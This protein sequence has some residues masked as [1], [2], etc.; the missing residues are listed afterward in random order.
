MV[1]HTVEPLSRNSPSPWTRWLAILFALGLLTAAILGVV[2]DATEETS[3]TIVWLLFT[4]GGAALVAAGVYAFAR[5]SAW[6]GLGLITVG[7]SCAARTKARRRE[8]DEAPSEAL[9]HS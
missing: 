6:L 1:Q 2:L 8:A 5:G 4:I 9:A 7:R 3:D